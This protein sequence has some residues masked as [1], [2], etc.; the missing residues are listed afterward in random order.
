VSCLPHE[1]VRCAG[2]NYLETMNSMDLQT[3]AR[4]VNSEAYT[5]YFVLQ[6]VQAQVDQAQDRLNSLLRELDAAKRAVVHEYLRS[7]TVLADSL[8]LPLPDLV[9]YIVQ[10]F[11]AE[12]TPEQIIDILLRLG[13]DVALSRDY[14]I[15]NILAKLTKLGLI[16]RTQ[17]GIGRRHVKYTAT[18]PEPATEA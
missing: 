1:P 13:A 4:F 18:K 3:N 15:Y 9:H 5:A 11:D 6:K 17:L 10:E 16:Q 14:R 12:F 8:K 2:M 7:G